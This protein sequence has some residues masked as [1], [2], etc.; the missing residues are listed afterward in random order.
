MAESELV[1]PISP[2]ELDKYGTCTVTT[3]MMLPGH[4][5]V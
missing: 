1:S 3:E 4:A 5:G 2:D